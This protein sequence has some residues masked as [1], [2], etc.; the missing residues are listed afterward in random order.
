MPFK[1]ITRPHT[2]LLARSLASPSGN[3]MKRTLGLNTRLVS[4]SSY[5]SLLPLSYRGKTHDT[6]IVTSRDT[7]NV[8][9]RDINHMIWGAYGSSGAGNQ[10]DE[11]IKAT[12]VHYP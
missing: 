10:G 3:V 12:S 4:W 8:V 2:I 11:D 6:N 1:P 7:N 5:L 9:T